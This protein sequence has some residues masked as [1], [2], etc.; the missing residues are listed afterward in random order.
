VT[1]A[2]ERVVSAGDDHVANARGVTPFSIAAGK[3]MAVILIVEDNRLIRD[4]AEMM[5]GECGYTTLSAG[6]VASADALIK[7]EHHIDVLFTDIRLDRAIAGGFEIARKAL[8]LRPGL[9][10]LYTSGTNASKEDEALFV[11]GAHFLQKPYHCDGL[12]ASL[13]A[14]LEA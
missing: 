5:I 7:S 10:V 3:T 12:E 14:L 6:D 8:L 11:K 2:S 4:Y 1:S 9:R 13:A